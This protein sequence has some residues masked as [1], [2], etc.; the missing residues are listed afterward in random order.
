MVAGGS[1]GAVEVI[2]ST[3]L[4]PVVG[5]RVAGAVDRFLGIPFAAA[6]AG[7]LRWRPPVDPRPWEEPRPAVDYGARCPQTLKE[8]APDWLRAHFAVVPMAEDCLSLNVWTP[9]ERDGPLPVM[10]YIHGGNMVFGSGS[11]PL[12]DGG[13]FA[14]DGVVLVTI[15]Y[16]LGYLGRFA[17]PALTATQAGEPLV[18]YGVM[19]QIAALKWVQRNIAA[20][21]G[22][23]GNVT[24][25]GHSA[26]GVSVN[27]LMVSPLAKGLFHRAIA[28]GSGVLLDRSRH[29]FEPGPIGPVHQSFQDVGVD[30]AAH[31]GLGAEATPATAAQLRALTPA[32]ILEYQNSRQ[33]SFAPAVDGTVI[34]DDLAEIFERGEQHDV[35]YIGGANS[36]EWN[37][38]A[39][40]V[41]LIG[42]WFLAGALLEGLNDDDLAPF[43]DQWTRIGVSQRWFAEGLFLTSTRYLAKQMA[44]VS[45]PAWLFHVTFVQ[46]SLRDELPGAVHGMEVPFLFGNLRE[47]PE[48]QR[49][50]TVPLTAA[51]HAWGDT[52][53]AYWV[54]FARSG[55]PNGTGRPAWPAYE[56]D[57]DLALELG[58]AIV[59]RPAPDAQTLDYLESRALAR[60][61]AFNQSVAS[62]PQIV[63]GP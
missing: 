15:N 30:L 4:G 42:Q 12:Y 33:I 2:V 18:N 53:R 23:P 31:F 38:I 1:A 43:D 39:V 11:L 63:S 19:D 16:R 62:P 7:D 29:A 21:G 35:P 44:N 10:V 55:D 20:F 52:L 40:G 41:P 37:Q 14:R 28:Q 51:D 9:A 54:A 26:G 3:D 8:S 22:D 57:S 56:P 25:F 48:Y 61:A 13:V 50:E 36:W 59:P 46:E 32:Q 27:F 60:R 49:P 5:Q 6:P 47:H 58:S 45:S 34:P 17:H 24:I